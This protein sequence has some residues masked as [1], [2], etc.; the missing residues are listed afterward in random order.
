MIKQIRRKHDPDILFIEPSEMVV[1]SEMRQVIAMAKRD[2]SLIAGP[3]ITLVDGANFDSHWKERQRLVIGQI[4]DADVVAVSR[5]DRISSS[6]MEAIHTRLSPY[7][8][9]LRSIDTR[10]DSGVQAIW[11]AIIG[12]AQN[13]RHPEK[14][15]ANSRQ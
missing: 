4:S 9:H 13:N 12:T 1:T 6:V 5:S 11:D 2:I 14:S 15:P 7:G 10:N 3:L 8:R